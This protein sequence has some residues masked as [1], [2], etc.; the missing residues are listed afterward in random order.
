MNLQLSSAMNDGTNDDLP[1]R[2]VLLISGTMNPPHRGHIMM[3]IHAADALRAK[4]C[5]VEAVYYVPVHDNYLLNKVKSTPKGEDQPMCCPMA[6]RTELLGYLIEQEGRLDLNLQVL[7]FES[8]HP[9]LLCESVYW[10]KKLPAGHLHTVPTS[11]LVRAFSRRHA[12]S[13][14]TRLAVVFGTDNLAA[15]PLWNDASA[16]FAGTDL[17]LCGRQ[18][19]GSITFAQPPGPL[20]RQFRFID[21]ACEVPVHDHRGTYLFGAVRGRFRHL[22]GQGGGG[23]APGEEEEEEDGED[24]AIGSSTLHVLPPLDGALE[25]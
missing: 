6:M 20:L 2:H 1:A 9:D 18:V 23:G 5:A 8:D 14:G 3:G 16:A 17:V 24:A 19:M 10:S 11:S 4:G 15:I 25:A 22:G 12:A 7:D 21:V 13:P